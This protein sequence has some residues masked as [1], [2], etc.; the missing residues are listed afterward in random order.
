VVSTTIRLFTAGVR[1]L[2]Y[3]WLA[4]FY[5]I[6]SV[7]DIAIINASLGLF[8]F[9]VPFDYYISLQNRYA[10]NDLKND[11]AV[12]NHFVF[13][14]ISGA[15]P[16]LIFISIASYTLIDFSI[17][18]PLSLLFMCELYNNELNRILLLKG[19]LLLSSF[20][21]FQRNAIWPLIIVTLFYFD[22][23]FKINE[24]V[25]L[26]AFFSF[27]SLFI[28][29]CK[30]KAWESFTFSQVIYS[31][32]YK[33]ISGRLSAGKKNILSTIAIRLHFTIDKY[34]VLFIYGKEELGLYQVALSIASAYM[35]L[36]DSI[37][38]P[39]RYRDFFSGKLSI[40]FLFR[41]FIRESAALFIIMA[42]FVVVVCYVDNYLHL[43]FIPTEPLTIML[44]LLSQFL[45]VTSYPSAYIL[46]KNTMFIENSRISVYALLF[47]CAG[48][49]VVWLTDL[50]IYYFIL[51]MVSSFGFAS[52]YKFLVVEKLWK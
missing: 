4:K 38:V 42:L 31:I 22:Y 7:A 46:I 18:I 29:Y 28:I 23:L 41:Q 3:I 21:L 35:I 49:G 9:I 30:F 40:L 33:E 37:V 14:S 24:I 6:E 19:R 13:L 5:S 12:F 51:I 8:I 1:M 26:W 17:V 16:I 34:S 45:F 32:S 48:I 44:L 11:K 36:I 43:G 47:F 27:L 50:N 10:N 20:L 52:Y 39:R 25:T 2:F 15:L